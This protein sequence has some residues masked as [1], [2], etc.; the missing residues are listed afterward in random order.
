MKETDVKPAI[1]EL[2]SCLK[3]HLD[4]TPSSPAKY[5]YIIVDWPITMSGRG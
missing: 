1:G 5:M 2:L 4:Y 3:S